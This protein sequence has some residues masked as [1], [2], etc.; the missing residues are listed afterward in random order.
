[1]FNCLRTQ[2]RVEL[3]GYMVTLYL[4]FW[5]TGFWSDCT[6]SHSHQQVWGF[7]FFPNLATQRVGYDWATEQQCWGTFLLRGFPGGSHIKQSA[8]NL[9]DLG[10]IPGSGRSPGEENGNPLQYS[11][12]KIPWMEDGNPM[13]RG[14]GVSHWL[15]CLYWKMLSS[16]E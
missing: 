13:D 8:C 3:L 6:I 12:W 15:I 2:L 14:Y 11:C 1:M 4:T 10:S 7:Q 16:L 5:G 9:G